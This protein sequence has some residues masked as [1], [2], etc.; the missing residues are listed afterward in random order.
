MV[1]LMQ[2]STILALNYAKTL[3]NK[4]AQKRY[5]FCTIWYKRYKGQNTVLYRKIWY[6]WQ[7]CTPYIKKDMSEKDEN[8]ISWI[9]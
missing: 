7:A 9:M 6:S 3:D 1:Q 8:I 2:L 5:I 4:I